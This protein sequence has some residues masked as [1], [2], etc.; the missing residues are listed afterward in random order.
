LL[1]SAYLLSFCLNV[2]LMVNQGP[3]CVNKII[4]WWEE[5][6]GDSTKHVVKLLL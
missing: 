5:L 1:L 4:C 3:Y 2:L 6:I